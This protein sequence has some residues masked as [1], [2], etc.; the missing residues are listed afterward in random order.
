MIGWKGNVGLLEGAL[1]RSPYF[2]I[3]KGEGLVQQRHH[4]MSEKYLSEATT[5]RV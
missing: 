1:F 4:L 5:R 2:K 3:S